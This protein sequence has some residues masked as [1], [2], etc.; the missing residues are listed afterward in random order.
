M[1]DWKA[2]DEAA[3]IEDFSSS[4]V[5]SRLEQG[6]VYVVEDVMPMH[7]AV[8]KEEHIYLKFTDA[9]VN[10][11]FSFVKYKKDWMPSQYFRKVIKDEARAAD[12]EFIKTITRIKEPA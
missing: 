6:N 11:P 7:C 4:G 8:C 2:G 12:K 3:C 1:N 9:I 10:N 5:F